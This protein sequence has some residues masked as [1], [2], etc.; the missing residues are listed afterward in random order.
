MDRNEA[1]TRAL[2]MQTPEEAMAETMGQLALLCQP[3]L[4]RDSLDA[5]RKALDLA[6]TINADE[7]RAISYLGLTMEVITALL[8]HVQIDLYGHVAV[9]AN[10]GQLRQT[11]RRVLETLTPLLPKPKPEEPQV[12]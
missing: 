2:R 4:L 8:D 11:A 1:L 3:A 12:P 9:S 7:K 10:Y 5:A 6:H